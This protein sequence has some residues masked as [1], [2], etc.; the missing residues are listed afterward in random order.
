MDIKFLN[1]NS[2]RGFDIYRKEKI[3]GNTSGEKSLKVSGDKLSVS[4]LDKSI[5]EL[6]KYLKKDNTYAEYKVHEKL[7]DIMIRI[8]DKTSKKVILEFPPEKIIDMIAKFCEKSGIIIN[9][10]V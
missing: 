10:K 6:N 5:Q 2:Y 9:N 8:V 1:D 7:G 4:D 3:A